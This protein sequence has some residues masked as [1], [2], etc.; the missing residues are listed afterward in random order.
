MLKR[1]L[2]KEE[3]MIRA[4]AKEMVDAIADGRYEDVAQEIDDMKDWDVELLKEV[5]ESYIEDN[6]LEQIDRFDV[7][8]TFKP[9]YKDHSVYQQ[10]HFYH[11]NDGSGISYEYALTTDGEPNDLT[12]SIEF[13]FE[14]DDMKV[15]FESGLT[16]L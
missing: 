13:R 6:E 5:I 7:G 8:C 3:D 9:V 10:E 4:F 1:I 11:L 16:V 15:I 12:L 2:G 14:G